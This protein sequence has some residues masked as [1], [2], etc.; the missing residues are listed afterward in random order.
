MTHSVRLALRLVAMATFATTI[1][2]STWLLLTP[3]GGRTA[4]C[5]M[6]R[7]M[8]TYYESQ[9]ASA[10]AAAQEPD[11]NNAKTEA[12]YQN[13]ISGLQSYADRIATPA[14]RSEADTIVAINRDMFEQWKRWV[15]Q[16]QSESTI[17]A[18]PTPSDRQF[19]GEFAESAKKL[20]AAHAELD[21]SCR[22]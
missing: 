20:G 18:G 11:A 13:M 2:V 21:S 1:A 9:L 17:S 14:I 16:S 3:P 5:A 10:R 6:A 19:G 15:A 4:D 12:A 7:A 22:S 8:W